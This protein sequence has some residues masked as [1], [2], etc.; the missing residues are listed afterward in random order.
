MKYYPVGLSIVALMFLAAC[1]ASCSGKPTQVP[2]MDKVMT[3][4]E[5]AARP[6]FRM[7]VLAL[8]ADH[9]GLDGVDPNCIHAKQSMH[10]VA[11]GSGDFPSLD[12]SL[13]SSNG[14]SEKETARHR[15]DDNSGSMER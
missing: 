3:V 7:G 8:C 9:P 6:D 1:L 11:S 12:I 13:P 5:F 14:E 2:T 4:E 10:A 15:N